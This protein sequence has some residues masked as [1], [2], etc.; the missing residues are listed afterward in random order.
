MK[1]ELREK[2]GPKYFDN[3]TDL[4]TYLREGCFSQY[5][6]NI[7]Y[8]LSAK[9]RMNVLLGK[10]KNIRI[11]NDNHFIKDAQNLGLLDIREVWG[12]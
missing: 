10:D 4:V 3:A 8:K 11:F 2:S 1:I 9:R 7:G 12:N 6:T 5:H